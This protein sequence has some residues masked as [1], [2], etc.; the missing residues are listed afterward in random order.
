M[1]LIFLESDLKLIVNAETK[2]RI[3]LFA[4]LRGEEIIEKC[5]INRLRI[6]LKK[7]LILK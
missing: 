7:L 5:Y 6:Y 2:I 4:K 3:I 1:I